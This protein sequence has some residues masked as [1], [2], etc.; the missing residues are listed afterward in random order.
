[1]TLISLSEGSIEE[2]LDG[3]GYG[4]ED[5]DNPNPNSNSI[6]SQVDNAKEVIN[7]PKSSDNEKFLAQSF[8]NTYG[9]VTDNIDNIRNSI[10]ES[11]NNTV[12]E[13]NTKFDDV[14][15]FGTNTVNQIKETLEKTFEDT[16]TGFATMSTLTLT[17]PSGPVVPNPPADENV[18]VN[19]VASQISNINSQVENT[20]STL[21]AQLKQKWGFM[22]EIT[23]KVNSISPYLSVIGIDISD[24]LGGSNFE[25]ATKLLNDA[26]GLIDN[27]LPTLSII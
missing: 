11:I 9:S 6:I 21:G 13:I 17:S 10:K 15:N 24:I 19:N 26:S 5:K 16:S 27:G 23:T 20:K 22:K 12:D 8:V 1:M 25:N 4:K 3:L 7:N 14:I 2:I 18:F